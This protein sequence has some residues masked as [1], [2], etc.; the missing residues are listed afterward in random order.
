MH[1]SIRGKAPLWAALPA[2]FWLI[3]RLT[4]ALMLFAALH[5]SAGILAQKITIEV[6]QASLP[7]VFNEISRQTGVSIMYDEDLLKHCKPVSLSIKDASLEE[8]MQACLKGQPFGYNLINGSIVIRQK[9]QTPELQSGATPIAPI[10]QDIRGKVI[11]EKGEPIPGASVT[12]QGLK[13]GTTTNEK[14]EF[15]LKNIPD[16]NYTLQITFVGHDK[17]EQSITVSGNALNITATLKQSPIN[18]LDESVVIAYG[19]TTTRLSAGDVTTITGQKIEQQPV[20][21]VLQALTGRVPGMYINQNTGIPG[22]GMTVRVQG[23]NSFS[24]GLDPL[25]IIDGV[26]YSSQLPPNVSQTAGIL[27]NNGSN[28]SNTYTGGGNPLSFIN[29]MDIESVSILKDADATAIYGSRAANGAVIITTKKGRI[30]QSKTD[31]NLTDGIG[32]VAHYLPELNTQQYLNLRHEALDNDG[33]TPRSTDYDLNGT[34]DTSHYTNWQKA[35]LGGTAHYTDAHATISGGNIGI[36]Y[37]MA[38][39]YHRE[40]T[41]FPGDL[42]DQK[43]SFHINLSHT[44]PNHRFSATT[45]VKYLYDHNDLIY[46]DLTGIAI[47][48]SPNAPSLY[49]NDGALNWAPTANGTSSWQ[50]P[51]SFLQDKYLSNTG[52]LIGNL[53]LSYK[54]LPGLEVKTNFGYNS[55]RTDETQINPSTGVAPDLRAAYTSSASYVNNNSTSW[56]IEPQISYKNIYKDGTLNVLVGSTIQQNDVNADFIE[57]VGYNNDL[58]LNS[59]QAASTI[60][61]VN[62]ALTQYNYEALFGRVN[63]NWQNKYLLDFNARRDASSRFGPDNLYHNFWSVGGA[64]IFSEEKVIKNYLHLLSFGKVR[65][66]Y[67]TTGNDQIGD[68]QFMSLYNSYAVP[69]SYQNS[70]GIIPSSIANPYLQ[71]EQTNKFQASLDLGFVNDRILLSAIYFDNKSSNLLSGYTLPFLTGFGLITANLPALIRNTGEEFTLTTINLKSELFSWKTNFNLT[72]L[73]NKL[74]KY[75]NLDSSAYSSTYFIGQPVT[76]TPAYHL[77]GVDKTTGLFQFDGSQGPTNTPNPNTDRKVFI[78]TDPKYYAGLENDLSYKSFGL[79]FLLQYVERT[80]ANYKFGRYPGNFSSAGN[81]VGYNNQPIWV[82]N[83]WNSPGQTTEMQKYSTKR[84]AGYLYASQ[85]DA[86]Y[87]SASF[88][89]L[90]NASF[91]WQVPFDNKKNKTAVKNLKIYLN[92]QNLITFTHYK[93]LDPET[94]NIT[95]LPPLRVITTGIQIGF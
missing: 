83:A 67:G 72:I 8:T 14:G 23:T 45:D 34:W 40:T 80:A 33:L 73:K 68:Y 53:D 28:N 39:G 44:S 7:A 71:W 56:I 20:S 4:T 52:N 17:F 3:M 32:K 54:V 70:T 92:C 64:W 84:A 27:G 55:L 25:Y 15:S 93:G 18:A 51:L 57:G 41:V 78:N 26:P 82:L 36:Q 86:A 29:P 35:L 12:L 21:N 58:S 24:S 47:R 46:Q 81:T 89:R 59:I 63:Y 77:L 6:K 62:N 90:K 88:L 1:L 75:P 43:A 85:S 69:V 50:N 10:R 13:G 19:T 2:Q 42:S 65:L 74:M 61:T 60:Y 76:V 94:G 22:G 66:S 5:V 91:Y 49:T 95:A 87:S 38:G 48:L 11:N 16:G 37:L 79:S 30:G 9:D 31:I